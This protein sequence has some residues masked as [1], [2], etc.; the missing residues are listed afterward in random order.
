MR[1]ITLASHGSDTDG[2]SSVSAVTAP[3]CSFDY[4]D[5]E[6][7]SEAKV[8]YPDDDMTVGK[9]MTQ[10]N[11]PA[12]ENSVVKT[13]GAGKSSIEDL[14]SPTEI[15]GCSPKEIRAKSKLRDAWSWVKQV[16]VRSAFP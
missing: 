2:G 11:H 12:K 4:L 8:K 3:L 1:C 5:Q 15:P 13:T 10:T 16:T 14:T 7:I 6:D 9:P